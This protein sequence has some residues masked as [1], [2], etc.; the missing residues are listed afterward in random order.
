MD[1]SFTEEQH[2]IAELA[3]SLFRE[4]GSDE[5]VRKLADA[6]TRLDAPLWQQLR[7]TGLLSLLLPE[8]LGGSGMGMQEFSLMLQQQG[9]F[10]AAAPLWSHQLATL[11]LHQHG[12][13]ELHD[14]LLPALASGESIVAL[15]TEL[16]RTDSLVATPSAQGWTLHGE[17]SAVLLEDFH[18]CVLLP[19]TTPQGPRLFLVDAGQP[20][21]TRTCGELTDM[22]VVCDLRFEQVP[23]AA[24]RVLAPEVFEWLE[25]RLA[26]ALSALSLGVIEEGLQRAA[27]YVSERTQFGRPLGSFQAL[28][29][30]A[31]DSYIEVELLRS[32]LW[33][34]AWRLDQ[35]LPAM[36]AAR[37]AKYQ[38]AQ[39]GHIVS[40]TTVHLH[41]G[42]GADLQY[43]I[44]R[45][46]LKA[47]ALSAM[48]GG[49]E[50]QLTR[51]GRALA[52]ADYEEYQYE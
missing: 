20:G 2:A 18:A 32:A 16:T 6:G 23:L 27:A 39:A 35:G 3:T 48:G 17:I 45:F 12:L 29:V 19:A 37:V 24:E 44:H 21:I 22:Q 42:V 31:A 49:T 43:P 9:R 10:L 33:Q 5:H 51:I 11:A 4:Y 41:G 38:A 7:E 15:A 47:Q 36:A 14:S 52:G 34:L 26:C 46:Y 13:P 40:H 8:E 28:A 25:P 1:F 50:E 30:R